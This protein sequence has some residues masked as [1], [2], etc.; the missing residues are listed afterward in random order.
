M[1]PEAPASGQAQCRVLKSQ[2]RVKHSLFQ[3]ESLAWPHQGRDLS[4][5]KKASSLMVEAEALLWDHVQL[6]WEDQSEG[7]GPAP[8][9]MS[10]LGPFQGTSQSS[11][12]GILYSHL[13]CQSDREVRPWPEGPV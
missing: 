9:P 4:G 3:E 1:I 5:V 10:I 11:E 2:G 8:C 13:S 6:A 12:K 7:G